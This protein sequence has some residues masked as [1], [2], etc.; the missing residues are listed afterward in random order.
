MGGREGEIPL[1]STIMPDAPGLNVEISFGQSLGAKLYLHLLRIHFGAAG[2][3][4]GI[5]AGGG[6]GSKIFSRD[7]TLTL[8]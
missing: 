8:D 7:S 1:A 4:G 6:G 2:E 3:A 5:G